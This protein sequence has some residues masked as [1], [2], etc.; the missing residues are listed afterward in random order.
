MHKSVA[1]DVQVQLSFD[2]TGP[3]TIIWEK[4]WFVWVEIVAVITI[5]SMIIIVELTT[6][7]RF[8]VLDKLNRSSVTD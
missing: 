5:T 3:T 6:N 1:F 7:N 2:H 8:D 4:V